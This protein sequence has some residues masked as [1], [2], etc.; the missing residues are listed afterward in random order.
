MIAPVAQEILEGV[1]LAVYQVM[2]PQLNA[3]V[4]RPTQQDILKNLG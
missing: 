1:G 3:D 4:I 2:A